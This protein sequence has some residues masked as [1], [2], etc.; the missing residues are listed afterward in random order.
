VPSEFAE[1][2]ATGAGKRS[3][4]VR[5]LWYCVGADGVE[6]LD[7]VVDVRRREEALRSLWCGVGER[8]FVEPV[9]GHQTVLREVLDDEA[10]EVDLRR[11]ERRVGE[12][13]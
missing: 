9:G 2:V 7:D 6:D 8:G 12:E 1:A 5:L 4:N 3:G 11:R 10:D 13:P